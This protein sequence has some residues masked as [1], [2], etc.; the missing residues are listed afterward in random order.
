ME[1]YGEDPYLTGRM[2]AAFVHGL[3]GEFSRRGALIAQ[4]CI[5]GR[6]SPPTASFDVVA[7][8]GQL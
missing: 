5:R 4:F 2:T 1:T 7:P 3:P 8:T 6:R